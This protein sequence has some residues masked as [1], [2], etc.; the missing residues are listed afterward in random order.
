[1]DR[2]RLYKDPSTPYG[3]VDVFVNDRPLVDLLREYEAPF[4]TEEEHPEIAGEYMGLNPAKV[5]LPSHRLL[6]VTDE[7]DY[8]R[9]KGKVTI[10]DCNCGNP[11]C[12]PLGVRVERLADRFIWSDFENWHREW[13]DYGRF[14]PF[15][16]E[17]GQ[18][19]EALQGSRSK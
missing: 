3:G 1:M 11:G 8:F 9:A 15:Q 14:G 5:F 12:W 7:L 10:L 4:A 19:L 16:F 6:G 18:Y 17:A 13:W 2:L